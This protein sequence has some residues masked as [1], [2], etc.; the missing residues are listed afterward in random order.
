MRRVILMLSATFLLPLIARAQIVTEWNRDNPVINL[1]EDDSQLVHEEH[2]EGWD[3]M[4]DTFSESKDENL[5]EEVL[6]EMEDIPE[7]V[8][9][10]ISM[11]GEELLIPS[12]VMPDGTDLY[13]LL[14][15]G[16]RIYMALNPPAFYEDIDKDV[17]KWVRFYAFSRKEYTRRIF[18]R[19]QE[20]A[21]YIDSCMEEKGI[22]TELGLLCL[23]E[24]GCSS[25]A[26]SRV[27]ATGMWQF[28]PQTAL[29]MGLDITPVTDDRT[30]P[31]KATKA[32]A[33]YLETAYRN[34]NNW[35]LAAASYNCGIG[36][37]QRIMK[38][39]GSSE[40]GLVRNHLP[41]ETRQYVPAL[42][43]IHYVWT[44]RSQLG[45]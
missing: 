37:V 28:M 17:V 34:I 39:N 9:K 38:K 3:K 14:D 6:Q 19:Y 44:Y 41:E 16:I 33:R 23:I 8:M 7:V 5:T 4:L 35:T 21:P 29:E 15:E 1:W 32:A 42:I 43:A 40:W 31:V 25:N 13:M 11:A 27:G 22:P 18:E 26:V 10:K 36:R 12:M 30:D 2:E 24:S 20:W 45:F